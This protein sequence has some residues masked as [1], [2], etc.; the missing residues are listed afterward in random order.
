MDVL[1][2]L[3]VV[4]GSR[5]IFFY[6]YGDIGRTEE[7]RRD[8][9]WVAGRLNRLY[10]W[11]LVPNSAAE[12]PVRMLSRYRWDPQG[13]PA[14]HVA[15]KRRGG[16]TLL[17]AVNSIGAPVT[18]E[19]TLPAAPAGSPE[20]FP[21]GSPAGRNE[22]PPPCAVFTELFGNEKYPADGG[23]LRSSFEA[24]ETKAFHCAR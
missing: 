24:Y 17:I 18:A 4:H 3:A 9:A 2:F 20:G 5:G 21:A 19:L 15:V 22:T 10:P 1:A 8:L 7:G 11:L 12:I 23:R 6:T 16:E 13:R 14:V